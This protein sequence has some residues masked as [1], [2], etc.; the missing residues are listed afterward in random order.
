[1]AQNQ[2]INFVG[3]GTGLPFGINKFRKGTVNS[4]EDPLYLTFFLDFSPTVADLK[5]EMIAFNSLLMD[6]ESTDIN[7]FDLSK[8]PD[9]VENSTL[10]YLQRAENKTIE[11]GQFLGVATSRAEHLR[12]FQTILNNTYSNA[13]WFFQQISGIS[14]L[15]KKATAVT[16][17][18]KKV[19]LTVNCLESVDMRILQ[20]ADAYRKAVYNSRTLSYFVPDNMRYFAF[21]LYLFEIR[22]LKEFSTFSK[23]TSKFT[24]GAHYIKFKCK[25]C[26]FD[27]SE[28]LSGG[29]TA[30]DFKAYTDE[31]AFEPSFKIDIGWVEEDSLYQDAHLIAADVA[32]PNF[33]IL[34]GA[35]DSISNQVQRQITNIAR[36]PARVIG[37]VVNE[38]Q[39]T[40][41]SVALGNAYAGLRPNLVNLSPLTEAIGSV[42][43]PRSTSPIGPPPPGP[44]D[45]GK[46]GGY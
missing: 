8:R 40:V 32:I 7:N 41:E 13:P 5:H 1:M 3:Q 14:D 21:D 17:G 35:I 29:P 23:D 9:N 6:M 44:T 31:K 22:N 16:E 2:H 11:D 37:S 34:N 26:E 27:F 38:F 25:M 10:E 39:T 42:Y 15:W 45:L 4:T 24:D 30:V 18:H 19:T 43:T 20:M 33:G 12:K 36:I 46:A 28:T